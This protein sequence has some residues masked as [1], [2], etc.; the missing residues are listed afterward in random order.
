MKIRI[1]KTSEKVFK[2][3]EAGPEVKTIYTVQEGDKTYEIGSR[4][5]GYGGNLFI[6]KRNGNVYTKNGKVYRQEFVGDANGGWDWTVKHTEELPISPLVTKAIVNIS[7][8]D[9]ITIDTDSMTV[10]DN[11]PPKWDWETSESKSRIMTEI[12]N[13]KEI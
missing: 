13:G 2:G 3:D 1:K 5:H 4:G 6:P 10:T 8:F 7:S 9:D 12:F 11:A